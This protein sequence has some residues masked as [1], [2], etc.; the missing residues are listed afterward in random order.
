MSQPDLTV[1]PKG[2]PDDVAPDGVTAMRNR[3]AAAKE[4]RQRTPPEPRHA[5]TAAQPSARPL[6]V[7][8]AVSAVDKISREIPGEIADEVVPALRVPVT[9]PAP[10]SISD[11][12]VDEEVD[13]PSRADVA[14]AGDALGGGDMPTP[15]VKET[16]ALA[17]PQNRADLVE[18]PVIALAEV[19]PA[20]DAQ[21]N[22]PPA[23]SG[24]RAA[25]SASDGRRL[26]PNLNLNLADPTA[27]TMAP[28]VLSVPMSILQR[29]EA[30]RTGAVSH[31]ALLLDALR[32]HADELPDLVLARRPGPRPGDLFP[33]RAQPGENMS[34]RPG[35]LRIRPNAGELRIMD[36]LTTWV[37][38][39]IRR[40][41]PGGRKVTRSEIAAAAL[42]K[43]LPAAADR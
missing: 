26:R 40:L 42:D 11:T 41:R 38:G 19:P 15:A 17:T 2:E 25:A 35:P 28:T 43:F 31:T 30:A 10:P 34:D 7:V 9:D 20:A 5:N 14:V 24:R 3:R 18:T 33:Y 36:A 27:M 16:A 22:A 39:E 8:P 12:P 37:N 1:G 21:V 6:T 29:F 23:R 13:Q 4:R 32:K